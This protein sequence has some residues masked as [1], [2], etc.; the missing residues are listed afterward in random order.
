[1]NL[2]GTNHNVT[3]DFYVLI[4]QINTTI[5]GKANV[6]YQITIQ[7]FEEYSYIFFF[8]NWRD[9]STKISCSVCIFRLLKEA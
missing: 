7:F 4:R 5:A 2:G 8:R 6:E 3:N 1:M 9:L